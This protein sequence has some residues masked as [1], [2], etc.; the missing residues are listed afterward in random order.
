[1]KN[2]IYDLIVK[3][4]NLT[5]EE[6]KEF[7]KQIILKEY[8]PGFVDYKVDRYVPPVSV[9]QVQE[10]AKNA[11]RERLEQNIDRTLDQTIDQLR[12]TDEKLKYRLFGNYID[13]FDIVIKKEREEICGE[14]HDFSEWEE[15]VGERPIFNEFG[16]I[17]GFCCGKWFQRQCYY[18]GTIQ[19]AWD[20]K[21]KQELT[22]KSKK[23]INKKNSQ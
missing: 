13:N 5:N 22:L 12:S 8:V 20:E 9:K 11:Y 15:R 4:R 14:I 16:I 23:L 7:L 10:S 1:M 6:Q 17:E 2:E 21:Q 18:C 3:F 19:K